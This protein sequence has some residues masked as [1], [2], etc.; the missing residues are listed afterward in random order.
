MTKLEIILLQPMIGRFTLYTRFLDNIIYVADESVD[1]THALHKFNKSHRSA[2]STLE[3]EENDGIAYLDVC[4][5]RRVGGSARPPVHGK[6]TW[7]GQCVNFGSFV[8][9]KL[10]RNLIR[11]LDNGARKICPEDSVEERLLFL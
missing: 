2:Q 5:R 1:I 10:K 7:N 9:F 4:L 6:A 8:P 11:C 3:K